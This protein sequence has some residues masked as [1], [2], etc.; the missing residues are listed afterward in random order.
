MI[1]AIYVRVSTDQQAEH[2]Y[3]LKTQLEACRVKAN[4][5]G[6]TEIIEFI[7]D[8]YSGEYLD[9]PAMNNL[10]SEVSEKK[11]NLV[12]VYDP[13]RLAR[14]L[15]HQLIITDEIEKSGAQ[16]KFVSV[17]FERS[18]E[19]KLFYSL[20]GAVAEFEK[21]K[22][23]ERSLRGKKGKLKTG[24]LLQDS[25][26]FGYD[27]DEEKSNYI[28][29][30]KEAETVRLIYKILL[31]QK[32]G[33]LRIAHILNDQGLRT[34]KGFPWHYTSVYRILTN[35]KYAGNHI[36]LKYCNYFSELGKKKRKLRDENEWVQVSVPAIIEKSIWDD[37]QKQ[38]SEN[39][40]NSSR[41]TIRIYLLQNLLTCGNCGRKMSIFHSSSNSP[42]YYGC[43]SKRG[44]SGN[45]NCGA[46]LIQVDQL[47]IAIW[48]TLQNICSDET[49]LKKYIKQHDENATQDNNIKKVLDNLNSQEKKLIKQRDTVMRWFSQQLL[50]DEDAEKK[51][52]EIKKQLDSIN[53]SRKKIKPTIRNKRTVSEIISIFK[54]YDIQNITT[55]E[56]K[57]VINDLIEDIKAERIDHVFRSDAEISI[58]ITFL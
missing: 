16:L 15:A 45:G 50:S 58:N 25:N 12:M 1:T 51:L 26:L 42:T 44:V 37:A 22:I 33:C 53:N 47:E 14:N 29:N 23:L 56:Q 27:W 4:E 48:S 10:R 35:E 9:R 49:S 5:F 40:T 54:S 38:L 31:E 18:A 17:T 55:I 6:A 19:G 43:R 2:G 21:A 34:L 3:S 7:D 41:K 20:R 24:K 32:I 57:Q 13:D 36:G 52:H 30:E 28:I 46:R 11:I 39:R 8:G